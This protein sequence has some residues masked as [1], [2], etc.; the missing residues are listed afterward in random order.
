M[1][2]R[3]GG[4]IVLDLDLGFLEEVLTVID[5]QLARLFQESTESEDPVAFGVSDRI[6]YTVGLGFTACQQYLTAVLGGCRVPKSVALNCGPYHG[7][8]KPIAAIVNAAANYWKHSSE[9]T[10]PPSNRAKQTLHA[11]RITGVDVKQPY[12]VGNVLHV[13]LSPL[14]LR[15]ERIVPFLVEWRNEVCGHECRPPA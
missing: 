3:S 12:A 8:G 10:D 11:L 9:W 5:A 14:P 2:L 7:T 1:I 15:F 4:E 13:L 6:E